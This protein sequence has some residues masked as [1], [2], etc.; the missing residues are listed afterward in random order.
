MLLCVDSLPHR[1]T[2]LRPGC[3]QEGS[4]TP[5]FPP[6]PRATSLTRGGLRGLTL[7][8][9]ASRLSFPFLSPL[10]FPP[11]S[12]LVQVEETGR[13]SGELDVADWSGFVSPEPPP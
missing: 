9:V 13:R 2:Y 11:P 1:D 12:L 6:D 7:P 5:A 4:R 3:A 10:S 8:A